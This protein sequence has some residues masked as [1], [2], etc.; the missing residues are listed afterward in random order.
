MARKNKNG[1]TDQ[2]QK[3]A[4][5]YR[6]DPERNITKA[7]RKAYP[8]CKRDTSA[9]VSGSK[10]LKSAN[11]AAYLELKMGK[12]EKVADISQARVLKEIARIGFSDLRR[13][14]DK[15]G[16]LLSIKDMPD[17]IA[18]SISS[19]EVLAGPEGTVLTINKIKTWDKNSALEKLCKHLGIFSADKIAVTM[20]HEE[21][22]KQ[23]SQP[24]K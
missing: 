16:K 15:N 2:Q 13:A 3:F 4:D 17:D 12:A 1:I 24:K 20:S 23:L 6:A 21:W 10:L 18:A 7:Y 11:V 14:F 5:L 8:K 19:I 22:V 9:A